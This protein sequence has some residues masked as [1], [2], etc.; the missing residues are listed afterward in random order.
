MVSEK[1][2]SKRIVAV[3][4]S[5]LVTLHV[6]MYIDKSNNHHPP[7]LGPGSAEGL[8][9]RESPRPGAR[10]F[11]PHAWGWETWIPSCLGACKRRGVYAFKGKTTAGHKENREGKRE[12]EINSWNSCKLNIFLK[13]FT[14]CQVCIYRQHDCYLPLRNAK[15]M[16]KQRF[17]RNASSETNCPQVS[18]DDRNGPGDIS[19]IWPIGDEQLDRVWLL[20][21]L[22]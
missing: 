8:E 21:S 18:E 7:S 17:N 12:K 11:D 6:Q 20:V 14:D 10:V 19:H 22:S 4:F 15:I 3:A 9:G 2:A 16:T 13:N 5:T 1:T